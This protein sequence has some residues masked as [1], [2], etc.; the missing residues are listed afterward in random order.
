MQIHLLFPQPVYCEKLG[1]TLIEDELNLFQGDIIIEVN[2]ESVSTVDDFVELIEEIHKT[3]R[4]S[5]LLKII[6]DKKILWVTI[7]FK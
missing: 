6:R 4:K 7:K 5:L 2:R 1:R 3:G